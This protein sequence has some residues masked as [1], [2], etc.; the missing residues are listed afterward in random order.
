MRNFL[1]IK[2]S[3]SGEAFS[4]EKLTDEA[5]KMYIYMK[6]CGKGFWNLS[7][8]DKRTVILEE[9]YKEYGNKFNSIAKAIQEGVPIDELRNYVKRETSPNLK[10]GSNK[11]KKD[12]KGKKGTA[13]G[14]SDKNKKKQQAFYEEEDKSKDN[15]KTKEKLIKQALIDSIQTK[16]EQIELKKRELF[17]LQ[18]ELRRLEGLSN[19]MDGN[20]NIGDDD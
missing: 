6:L 10:N 5:N 16:R 8:N 13:K 17:L 1:Q 15:K 7:Y 20:Y 3:E 14:L 11:G 2:L 19:S 12:F 9:V 4:D 18:E